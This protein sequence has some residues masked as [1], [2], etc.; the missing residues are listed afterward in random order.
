MF[1]PDFP[2]YDMTDPDQVE[3]AREVERQRTLEQTQFVADQ[4]KSYGGRAF[5]SMLLQEANVEGSSF[6]GEQPLT[7]AYLEGKR[8]IGSWAQNLV[9]TIAPEMFS[10][11]RQEVVEREQRY[12]ILVGFDTD[13]NQEER[14][15]G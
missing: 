3:M 6:S 1:I 11:M 4:M 14:D 5:V 9:L 2:E 12:A 15:D 10:L 7:M 13:Q 8:D